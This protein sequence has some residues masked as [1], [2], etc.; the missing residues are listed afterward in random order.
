[1]IQNQQDGEQCSEFRKT[2][3]Q[4]SKG[5]DLTQSSHRRTGPGLTQGGHWA[6]PSHGEPPG[7]RSER[8]PVSGFV[9]T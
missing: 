1:M 9:S 8:A 6:A 5:L 7:Y 3:R 4:Q 2:T